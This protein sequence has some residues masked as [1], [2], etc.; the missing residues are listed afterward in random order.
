M[1]FIDNRVFLPTEVNGQGPFSFLIDTGSDSSTIS[2][3]LAER[4]E[5]PVL[6]DD[7]GG[8]AGEQKIA[9]SDVHVESLAVAGVSLGPLSIPAID[10]TQLMRVVGFQQC[11]GILGSELFQ[12]HAVTLDVDKLRVVVGDATEFH[13]SEG[14]VGIPIA[15]ER[16]VDSQ[17][18]PGMPVFRGEVNGV[19]G[20]FE[21]DTG[22]RS[23]VTLYSPFWRAHHLDRAI[24]KTLTA[25][26]GYGVGGPIRSIVGR[27][28]DFKMAGLKVRSPLV[29]LSLQRSGSFT[30]SG[31]AG[32]I[33][34]GLLKGF[35]V[36]FDYLHHTMWLSRTAATGTPDG[37]DRSGLWLGL[38]NGN[39][40]EIFDVAKGSP[41]DQ[42][43]L[44]VG[45][46][47]VSINDEPANPETLFSLRS[48]LKA[49]TVTTVEVRA[50]HGLEEKMFHLV[51]HDQIALPE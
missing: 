44:A 31:Y 11:D 51:L 13:P 21:I 43:G 30:R 34:M 41:A 45:D 9:Y 7:H 19:A 2:P 49:S 6:R 14:A 32:S 38:D 47:V 37:Y 3:K 4:L 5:L 35:V 26:T 22:D 28:K 17:D 29:R 40:L 8:G 18:N 1:S 15:F 16:A 24:G 23:S 39:D 25:M 42:V 33:G 12:Q 50:R 20:R 46:K 36:S 10:L 27:L 48:L